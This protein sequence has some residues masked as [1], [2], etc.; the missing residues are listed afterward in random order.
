MIE[1]QVSFISY[2][3]YIFQTKSHKVFSNLSAE[4]N[5]VRLINKTNVHLPTQTIAVVLTKSATTTGTKEK[6]ANVI[7]NLFLCIESPYLY[8]IP[9]IIYIWKGH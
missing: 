9:I 1:E 4:C 2:D 7:V 3:C 6:F 8:M 5:E